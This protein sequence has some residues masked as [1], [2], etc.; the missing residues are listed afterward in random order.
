MGKTVKMSFE[1][2]KL[3]GNWQMDRILIILKKENGPRASS[4]PALGLNTIIFKHVYWYMQQISGERLQDHWSS[5]LHKMQNN[6]RCVFTRVLIIRIQ[7]NYVHMW[8]FIYRAYIF[9]L[10]LMRAASHGLKLAQV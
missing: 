8:L 10:I 5:G 2:K 9:Y 3:A 1:G 6:V 4:A 7:P